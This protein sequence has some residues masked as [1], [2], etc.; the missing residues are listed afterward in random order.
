MQ[1]R[2]I[3]E[4]ACLVTHEGMV[5]KPEI[6]IPLVSTLTE[7]HLQREIV[8]RVASE[9]FVAAGVSV[10]YLV[11]TM[12]ELPRAALLADEIATPPSMRKPAVGASGLRLPPASRR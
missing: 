8:D 5:V 2:A 11:G 4:A 10:P 7:L 1:A 6:M 3:F 12:I 9:V